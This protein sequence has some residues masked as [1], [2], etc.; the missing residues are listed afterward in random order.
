MT[1]TVILLRNAEDRGGDAHRDGDVNRVDGADSNDDDD[2][3]Y[4]DDDDDDD[5]DENDDDDEDGDADDCVLARFHKRDA[6]RN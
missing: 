3:D 5:D 1:M 6:D 2:D 4:Y